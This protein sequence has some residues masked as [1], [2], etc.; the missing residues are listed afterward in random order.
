MNY[1]I[2]KDGKGFY[3]IRDT[4]YMQLKEGNLT[5]DEVI[6]YI[7]DSLTHE[8][9]HNVLEHLFDWGTSQLFDVIQH[10]FRDEKL[11]RRHY[12]TLNESVF[13]KF[14]L[15]WL[16]YK[17]NYGFNQMLEQLRL[18]KSDIIR[19]KELTSIRSEWKMNK[20]E[21]EEYILEEEIEKYYNKKYWVSEKWIK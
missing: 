10:F 8:H 3:I 13:F 6:E 9:I 18:S 15:T 14:S 7:S 17:E 21:I 11:Q 16:E 12:H 20:R 1:E 19:I 5:D 4:I 2:R